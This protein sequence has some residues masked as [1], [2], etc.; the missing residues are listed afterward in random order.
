[1][2]NENNTATHVVRI[3][4]GIIDVDRNFKQLI[5]RLAGENLNSNNDQTGE[6]PN[7]KHLRWVSKIILTSLVFGLW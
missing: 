7:Y 4:V 2:E 3:R 1:V 5:T 6:T